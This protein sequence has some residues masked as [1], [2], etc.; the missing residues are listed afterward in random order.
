MLEVP[1]R[2]AVRRL[3][4]KEGISISSKCRDLIRE[5]LEL[6]EDAYWDKEAAAREKTAGK[7]LS[8]GEAWSR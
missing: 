8:H 4:D 3:A 5:A 7:F 6:E 1:V 2:K